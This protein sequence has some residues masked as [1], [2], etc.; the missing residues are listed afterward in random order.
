VLTLQAERYRKER[1]AYLRQKQRQ[2]EQQGTAGPKGKGAAAGIKSKAKKLLPPKKP[3][4]AVVRVLHKVKWRE[5]I[6]PLCCHVMK[7]RE[8]K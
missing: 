3:K 2:E 4:A 1:A 6:R 5:G 8:I 7:W